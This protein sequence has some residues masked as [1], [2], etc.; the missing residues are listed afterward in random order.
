MFFYLN[1]FRAP[2]R[3]KFE[4]RYE[5]CKSGRTK[6]GTGQARQGQARQGK[7]RQGKAGNSEE[8]VPATEL[9]QNR[10]PQHPTPTPT[11]A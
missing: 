6:Q 2:E 3:T 11:T 7:A 4:S 8:Q 9:Q 10:R 5:T 1:K